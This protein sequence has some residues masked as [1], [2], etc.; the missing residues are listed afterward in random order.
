MA[1]E[2][3]LAFIRFLVEGTKAQ[4]IHW[5]PT[6]EPDQYL[7]SFKG[8][9]SVTIDEARGAYWLT[10]LSQDNIQMLEI[11]HHEAPA[12]LQ[13]LY[14]LAQREANN[15]DAAIDDIMGDIPF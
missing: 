15:V 1:T 12:D 6:A 5:E 2:K 7:T 8:K 10:M 13:E 11:K 3:D 4:T 9:Y 14:L